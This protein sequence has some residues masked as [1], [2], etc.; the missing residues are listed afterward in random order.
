MDK[1]K[2][3]KNLILPTVNL[4]QAESFPSLFDAMHIYVHV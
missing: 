4:E 1:M 2:C 3:V